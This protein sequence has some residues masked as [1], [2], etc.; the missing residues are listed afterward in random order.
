MAELYYLSE[1]PYTLNNKKHLITLNSLKIS[2]ETSVS[3]VQYYDITPMKKSDVR[4]NDELIPKPTDISIGAKQINVSTQK[5]HPYKSHI[6]RCAMFPSYHCPDDPHTGI[7]AASTPQVTLIKKS[8]GAPYRHELLEVPLET[9]RNVTTWLGENGFQNHT[10]PVQDH[11][12]VFYPKALKTK[13]P[14][15]TLRDCKSTLS[16]GTANMLQNL[17]K[18]HWLTS[19]QLQFS[20]TGPTNPIKLD[21][22]NE[23]TISLITGEMNPNTANLRERSYP[24]F[25]SPRPLEGRKARLLQNRRPLESSYPSP[26]PSL[27]TPVWDQVSAPCPGALEDAAENI[28]TQD[29]VLYKNSVLQNASAE[30]FKD[31]ERKES[32]LERKCVCGVKLSEHGA[33][34]PQTI[35]SKSAK[36]QHQTEKTNLEFFLTQ[37]IFQPGL[38]EKEN[39]VQRD[40]SNSRAQANMAAKNPFELCLQRSPSVNRTDRFMGSHQSVKR[41]ENEEE[42]EKRLSDTFSCIQPRSYSA[43]FRYGG[44]TSRTS[45]GTG[46]FRSQSA[47]LELQDSF[48]QSEAHRKFREN[49]HGTSMDLRDNQHSGR[50]HFFYGFNSYYFHN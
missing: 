23:K 40:L 4:M 27:P 10:K 19:Y 16:Q 35:I 30:F 24:V 28:S 7:R 1:Q 18:T 13:C 9:K 22:F 2:L 26:S 41:S 33:T 46:L 48:S 6:S 17:E 29:Y 47:L 45:D 44:R 21:G 8:K 25:M 14:N 43:P 36:T 37:N 42:R 20:G 50:K 31:N 38:Q 15:M 49:L 5:E 32:S 11:T 3:I 39:Q 12:Q 34:E